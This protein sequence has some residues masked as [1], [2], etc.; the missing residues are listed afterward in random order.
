[1]AETAIVVLVSEA[2]PLIGEHR[3]RHTDE[4]AHGMGA[5][6]TLLYPFGDDGLMT[7]GAREVI[8]GFDAFDFS[9]IRLVRFPGNP[10]V[11]CLRPDPDTPFRALTRAL[12]TRFPE[13]PPYGGKYADPIPHATVA[14]GD[15]GL[16]DGIEREVRP[17]LPIA[18]RAT[19]AVLM[20]RDEHGTWR[21]RERLPLR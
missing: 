7:A 13:H 5:H 18:A 21:V 8:R 10:R 15:D 14:I 17:A 9:L 6:V 4:G 19:E 3:R 2:E 20:N 16:L 1:M 12:A 11:L